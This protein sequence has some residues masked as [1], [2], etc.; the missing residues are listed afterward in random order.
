[1]ADYT[2]VVLSNPV[3]G[4]EAEFENWYGNTHLD[5]VVAVDGFT[6][7]RLFKLADGAA[8]GAPP[9]RY[10]AL[11]TMATDDPGKLLDDLRVLVETGQMAM[12]EAFSQEGLATHLYAPITPL[13]KK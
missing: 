3:S 13:I 12:S 4:Q 1:M 7:A 9:Q 5:D 10:M 2:Y 6:S 11:Y 8:E